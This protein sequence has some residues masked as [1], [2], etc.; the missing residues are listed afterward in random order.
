[1]PVP[2]RLQDM[3]PKSAPLREMNDLFA[4]L[5]SHPDFNWA[6]DNYKRRI[7]EIRRGW[8]AVSSFAYVVAVK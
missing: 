5:G 3:E 2:T 7:V 6:W 4:N 8:R 1:M